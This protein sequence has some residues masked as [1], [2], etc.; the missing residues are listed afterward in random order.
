MRAWLTLILVYL[1]APQPPLNA[2]A[3]NRKSLGLNETAVSTTD[4]STTL[5]RLIDSSTDTDLYDPMTISS[6][7]R[8]KEDAQPEIH[9]DDL[10]PDR[11]RRV[12]EKAFAIQFGRSFSQ[13]INRSE[14]KPLYHQVQQSFKSV[15]DHFRYSLQSN[16]EGW[17]VSKR[18]VGKRLLELSLEFN[19]KQGVDPQL[20][21]GESVRFRYD[22]IDQRPMLEYGFDF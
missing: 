21:I 9:P 13:L 18:K 6:L 14:L 16:S 8:L 1:I 10:D 3:P 7:Q 19:V 11:T 15:Q 2:E 12:V 20:R 4:L 5:D 22:Y 17:T